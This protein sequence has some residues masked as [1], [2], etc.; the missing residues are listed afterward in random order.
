MKLVP[1]DSAVFGLPGDH[2]NQICLNATHSD[3]CRFNS[4]ETKDYKNYFYVE[5]YVLELC[6]AAAAQGKPSLP[7]LKQML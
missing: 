6:V 7:S 5:A 1:R 3:M 4:S 2:E